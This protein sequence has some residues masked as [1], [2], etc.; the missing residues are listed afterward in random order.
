MFISAKARYPVNF[1][2]FILGQESQRR[3]QAESGQRREGFQAGETASLYTGN[4]RAHMRSIES[5]FRRIALSASQ[6]ASTDHQAAAAA[7]ARVLPRI[8]L[9]I[10]LSL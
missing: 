8:I 4:Y 2:R 6:P 1:P 10:V 5:G 7:A 3:G 9:H